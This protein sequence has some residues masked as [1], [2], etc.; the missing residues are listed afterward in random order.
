MKIL[1]WIVAIVIVFALGPVW[2]GY[3]LSILWT[4]FLVPAF[5]LPQIGI[6]I[7]I[8]TSV[9]VRLF[10]FQIPQKEEE[11]KKPETP[12]KLMVRISVW[13]FLYPLY[14]LLF[15]YIVHLFV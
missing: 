12:E 2:N 8:G 1:G 9:V 13:T 11:G 5:H 14:V 7:A 4:W 6:A 15:G 10:T 3:V